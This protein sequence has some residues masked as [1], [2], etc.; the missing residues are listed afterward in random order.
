MKRFSAALLVAACGASTSGSQPQDAHTPIDTF[1]ADARVDAHVDA[2][3]DASADAPTDGPGV[4]SGTHYHYILN[5]LT[6]PRSVT[7]ARTDGFDLNNDG[8]VDNQLGMVSSTLSVLGLNAQTPEDQAIAHGTVLMLADLQ[9][10]DLTT[11]SG[12]GYTM[13]LGT[14]PNPAPCNGASD[15]ICGHHL[16]GT[17]AFDAAAT[18]RD[19]QLIGSMTSGV[20]TAGPGHLSM[21]LS[22]ATSKPVTVTL[23]GARVKLTVTATGI[24]TGILGGAIP[25]G[26][27][28][29]TIFPAMQQ[30]ATEAIAHDCTG[31]NPPG[32]GCAPNSIGANLI[33]TFDANHNCAVSEPEIE[34]NSIVQSMFAPDVTI[35]GQTALSVGFA[36]TGVKATFTP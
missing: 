8:T 5:S 19:P 21:G 17:G 11:A 16:T 3:I 30:S 2:A 12:A 13:Y 29:S 25:V 23:L 20:L 28:H 6:W 36:V 27:F 15:T 26:D 24:T 18:P 4:A 7:E 10:T 31:M 33:V 34:N 32:C 9:T 14:D 35:D 1:T 22:I